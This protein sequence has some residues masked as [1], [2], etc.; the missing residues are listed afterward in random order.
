[1][2]LKE[3]ILE[4]ENPVI[5]DKD[6]KFVF[7]PVNK[8]MQTTLVRNILA[9]RCVVYKDNKEKWLELFHNT[10]FDNIYKFGII[11]NPITKFES[12]FNYLK[13]RPKLSKRMNIHNTNINDYV[14]NVVVHCKNPYL[15]N[16]HFEKQYE[17]MFFNNKQI[18]NDLFKV[19][20]KEHICEMYAK[21]GIC[22]N[23][24]THENKSEHCERLNDESIAILRKIYENDVNYLYVENH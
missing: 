15:L 22:E 8:V 23:N 6:G 17:G 24:N 4:R 18:V 5:F 7:F 12:A 11:R 3:Y 19:E 20:N 13:A 10:D 21:L 1:M 9:K 2:S 14:K 16:P